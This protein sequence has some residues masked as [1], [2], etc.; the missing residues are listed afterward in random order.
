MAATPADAPVC[1][2]IPP[3][4]PGDPFLGRSQRLRA[5]SR[6]SERSS[7]AVLR[8]IQRKSVAQAEL[9]AAR[10]TKS[11]KPKIQWGVVQLMPQNPA[12]PGA[13][14][15][16][17]VGEW[18]QRR[19]GLD[20]DCHAAFE[21][22]NSN[23]RFIDDSLTPPDETRRAAYLMHLQPRAP[24]IRLQL[25]TA[26]ANPDDID[27]VPRIGANGGSDGKVDAFLRAQIERL[28]VMDPAGWLG[29]LGR[30]VR[31]A[32]GS[33]QLD[34]SAQVCLSAI[35]RV[36]AKQI[37]VAAEGR[38]VMP[39][40][41]AATRRQRSEDEAEDILAD[42][43]ANWDD[44]EAK[45]A[46]RRPSSGSTKTVVH[47]GTQTTL[48]PVTA[49]PA[50][51]PT[52]EEQD[53]R[54]KRRQGRVRSRYGDDEVGTDMD[55][56][57]L[58]NDEDDLPA[59]GVIEDVGELRGLSPSGH[60]SRSQLKREARM[61]SIFGTREGFEVDWE[62]AP[63]TEL[64]RTGREQQEE[65]MVLAGS[66]RVLHTACS[67][68]AEVLKQFLESH[69]QSSSGGITDED[70]IGRWM[71]KCRDMKGRNGKPQQ[72]PQ[73]NQAALA[74]FNDLLAEVLP[75]DDSQK[76][77]SA[78]RVIRSAAAHLS[79][80]INV[81]RR[82]V[83]VSAAGLHRG[84]VSAAPEALNP[85]A[86][87]R[88]LGADSLDARRLSR[89]PRVSRTS[90]MD[91][92]VDHMLVSSPT[93]SNSPRHSQHGISPR[94]G[95]PYAGGLQASRASL[96]NRSRRRSQRRSLFNALDKQVALTID[97]GAT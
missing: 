47:K 6:V 19:R 30:M 76:Q 90:V 13:E 87:A 43:G 63:E 12:V 36:M 88:R 46:V 28:S 17:L 68:L 61:L 42:L 24:D 4:P 1:S 60:R 73:H 27:D 39:L 85:Y 81:V 8:D 53:F 69:I 64:R 48:M 70:L 59:G 56:D 29:V 62:V 72:P 14:E 15:R 7:D 77:P 51:T 9:G 96:V 65:L 3:A 31:L 41:A 45:P 55:P 78:S 97:P 34:Q 2:P 74:S 21:R 35:E 95:S 79:R 25:Q 5:V 40:T 71:H 93:A 66:V 86:S 89:Q 33:P 18:S 23:L 91:L 37:R 52:Q 16:G 26:S 10:S 83:R 92:G 84:S 67:G 80:C 58:P 75:A 44:T 11:R 54:P 32:K 94:Q 38:Q 50:C 20:N 22:V 82:Y 57:D 49:S